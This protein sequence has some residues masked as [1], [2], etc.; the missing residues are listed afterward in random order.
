M[1]RVRRPAVAGLFYPGNSKELKRVIETFLDNT[2]TTPGNPPKALI[3]PHAGYIYSGAVAASAYVL[4][5][6]LASTIKRVILLGPSHR[7]P[8]RG[9]ALPEADVFA[10]PLGEVALE[11]ETMTALHKFPQITTNDAAHAAEHSLEVHLPFLQTL[12][13]D[14]SLIPLV[15]GETTPEQV[16]EVLEV[17]WGG[18]ETLIV[19]STDL[20]HYND[21]QTAQR[22]DAET[23]EAIKALRYNDLAH[24]QAC[25]RNPVRGLLYAAGKHNMTLDILDLRNSGDTAGARDQVVGYGAYVLH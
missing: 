20:S 1:T 10:S 17:L 11:T 25:G 21:Y 13:S 3:V 18:E 6:P 12:L 15:V 24:D 23:S 22:M 9:L 16:A 7:V 5:K 8:L 4:L 14:F 19:V 2:Q